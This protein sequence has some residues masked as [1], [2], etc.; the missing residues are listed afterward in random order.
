LAA[1]IVVF[2]WLLESR[3]RLTRRTLLGAAGY[4]AI[5]VLALNAA[6][7]FEGT[8]RRADDYNWRSR[9]LQPLRSLPV[10]LLL[11]RTFVLGLDFSFRVQEEPDVGRGNNYVLGRL[12]TEGVFYAFPV[13]VLLKTPLA[14]F[15]LLLLGA[16]ARPPGE[17]GA[18]WVLVPFLV[19]LLFFSLL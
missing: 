5:V 16:R 8:F 11:P 3:G 19:F 17:P 4:C 12:N 7:G 2:L 15:G 6:Y 1:P 18:A 14:F 10:P 9:R 13:M